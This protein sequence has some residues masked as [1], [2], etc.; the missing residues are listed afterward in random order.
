M[1][2]EQNMSDIRHQKGLEN[3]KKLY[4]EKGIQGLKKNEK[5]ANSFDRYICDFAYGDI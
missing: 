5:L 1:I 4:G 2:K 3:I